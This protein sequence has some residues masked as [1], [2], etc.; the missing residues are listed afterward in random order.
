VGLLSVRP[1]EGSWPGQLWSHYGF[2]PGP[3]GVRRRKL[4]IYLPSSYSPRRRQQ[5]VY[6]LDGQN[7]FGLP[8]AAGGGWKAELVLEELLA[9]REVGPTVLVGVCHSNRRYAEYLGWTE[10]PDYPADP[11][12]DRFST[13][14]AEVVRPYVES[15]IKV[16]SQFLVGCSAGGV[17]ALYTAFRHPRYYSGVASLSAG[18]GFYQIL[19]DRYI[20]EKLPFPVFLSCGGRG[21]DREFEEESGEFAQELD[22]RGDIRYRHDPRA[23]H[24]EKAWA[25]ILPEC[26]SF[27][28]S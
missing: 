8:G 25:R 6:L 15:L 16:R 26:F 11:A 17:A 19:L 9:G 18:R 24:H 21:M 13:Y 2:E 23:S 1:V 27:L 4:L 10:T 20:P 14:L 22:S 5:V 28:L 7:A 12:A 3:T